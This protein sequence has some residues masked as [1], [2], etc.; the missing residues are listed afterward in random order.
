MSEPSANQE[1]HSN[2]PY[3]V[4]SI[5]ELKNQ[6][7]AFS[8]TLTSMQVMLAKLEERTSGIKEQDTTKDSLSRW[9]IGIIFVVIS[10]L[11]TLYAIFGKR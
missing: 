10:A 4:E 6:M 1:S 3:V 11:G 8:V 9:L 2:T 7:A 5:R